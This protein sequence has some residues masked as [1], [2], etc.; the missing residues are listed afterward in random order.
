MVEVVISHNC[1]CGPYCY[2][3]RRRSSSSS[4]RSTY[5]RNIIVSV[6]VVA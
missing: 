3:R 4:S 6:V 2:R 1:R 5:G